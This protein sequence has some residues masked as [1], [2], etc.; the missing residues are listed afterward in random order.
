MVVNRLISDTE[1]NFIGDT[2]NLRLPV[3][4]RVLLKADISNLAGVYSLPCF[5]DLVRN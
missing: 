2:L 4:L 1:L 5:A 3:V